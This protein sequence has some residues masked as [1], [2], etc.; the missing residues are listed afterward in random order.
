MDLLPLSSYTH[1]LFR[2]ISAELGRIAMLFGPAIKP[3]FC[4]TDKQH[5]S[6]SPFPSLTD[7]LTCPLTLPLGCHVIAIIKH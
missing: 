3:L 4:W 7:S 6:I 1:I 5:K 2:H